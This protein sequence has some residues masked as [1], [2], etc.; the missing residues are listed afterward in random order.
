MCICMEFMDTSIHTFYKT[1]HLLNE[2]PV[3]ILDCLL[4]RILHNV[5]LFFV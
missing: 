5:R 2:I 3:G 4:R 1:M